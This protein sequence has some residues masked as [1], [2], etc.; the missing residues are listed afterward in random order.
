MPTL[1]DLHTPFLYLTREER[2]TL[3]DK[4]RKN[5]WLPS[6]V[7]SQTLEEAIEESKNEVGRVFEDD[8]LFGCTENV[9]ETI[10]EE[11]EE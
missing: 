10:E 9:K 11:D 6:R 5:R 7:P 8:W 1:S 2:M 4:V 3:M